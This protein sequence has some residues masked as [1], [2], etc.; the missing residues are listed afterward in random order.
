MSGVES[1]WT[2]TTILAGSPE[3]VSISNAKKCWFRR[4]CK[5]Y[6]EY[7]FSIRTG[8]LDSDSLASKDCSAPL[9]LLGELEWT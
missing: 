3:L 9:S 5:C 8:S 4:A 6:G 1:F 7:G 2:M